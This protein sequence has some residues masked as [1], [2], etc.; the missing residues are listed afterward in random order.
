M[1]GREVWDE[2]VWDKIREHP[3]SKS[4]LKWMEVVKKEQPDEEDR[5]SDDNEILKE[6]LYATG[7]THGYSRLGYTTNDDMSMKDILRL[8]Q[9]PDMK[10]CFKKA[11][12]VKSGK[13]AET[14]SKVIRENIWNRKRGFLQT[15]MLMKKKK[16]KRKTNGRGRMYMTKNQSSQ[17]S[18]RVYG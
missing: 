4:G 17:N 10:K 5:D 14:V 13:K 2:L 11:G 3:K 6:L 16:K 12:I 18:K 1:G 8:K 9:L 15:V 7:I